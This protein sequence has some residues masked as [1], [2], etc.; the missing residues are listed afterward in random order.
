MGLSL[1]AFGV[2]LLFAVAAGIRL[3]RPLV[4]GFAPDTEA[5]WCGEGGI[6]WSC[7]LVS[8]FQLYPRL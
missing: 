1:P 5:C 2:C 8:V 6:W 4:T 7:D 3:K